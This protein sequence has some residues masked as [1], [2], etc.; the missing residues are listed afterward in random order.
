MFITSF[1]KGSSSSA[2]SDTPENQQNKYT[3]PENQNDE[4]ALSQNQENVTV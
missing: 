4:S 2:S 3:V 1:L